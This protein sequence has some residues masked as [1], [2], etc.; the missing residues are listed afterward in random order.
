MYAPGYLVL[1][2]A[3]RSG[4]YDLDQMTEPNM[5]EGIRKGIWQRLE[6]GQ[7]THIKMRP[8]RVQWK[9]SMFLPAWPFPPWCLSRIL[10]G[11][12]AIFSMHD[13]LLLTPHSLN[14]ELNL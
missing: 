4:E 7:N 6:T 10:F 2:S 13:A 8:R 9:I 1:E 11:Q 14:Y 3:G 12:C 5:V